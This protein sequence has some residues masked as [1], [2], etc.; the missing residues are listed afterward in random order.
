MLYLW[1]FRYLAIYQY[2]KSFALFQ[3]ERHESIKEPKFANNP[4]I[5]LFGQYIV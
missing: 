3:K 4:T 1:H 2:F 5:G